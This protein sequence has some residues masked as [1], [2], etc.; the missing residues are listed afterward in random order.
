M[1]VSRL[2]HCVTQITNFYASNQDLKIVSG[3]PLL[4]LVDD[5]A[6]FD[7]GRPVP[8]KFRALPA[9]PFLVP[10]VLDGLLSSGQYA[11]VIEMVPGEADWYCAAA[12]RKSGGMVLTG[13][14]DLL[15][16]D[17]GPKGG[18]IFYD[19]L[20]LRQ[21]DMSTSFCVLMASVANS[22]ETA[23]VL[24]VDSI[25]RLAFELKED[26]STTLL[27]AVRRSN[28]G[29]GGA[30][31]KALYDNFSK[32]YAEEET[33]SQHLAGN[34]LCPLVDP[35]LSELV[36]QFSMS[37]EETLHM[38]LP[39]II[40]DPSRASAWNVSQYL[41]SHAYSIIAASKNKLK[42]PKIFE[43]SRRD[44]R[45]VPDSVHIS[46]PSEI[47]RSTRKLAYRR[48]AIKSQFPAVPNCLVWRISA[49][50][51]VY[52][53]YIENGR[54]LPSRKA[55]TKAFCGNEETFI[56]WQDVHLSAQIQAALY[57]F[58][59]LTQ[60][61]KVYSARKGKTKL[62]N[63]VDESDLRRTNLPA[64]QQLV[65]SRQESAHF[66]TLDLR[67]DTLFEFMIGFSHQEQSPLDAAEDSTASLRAS[68]TAAGI[69]E[70]QTKWI[71]VKSKK[72]KRQNKAVSPV[73]NTAPELVKNIYGVLADT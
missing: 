25:Q 59:L 2:E 23:K 35:R 72:V 36:V 42:K 29:F 56:S 57:S 12:A 69:S 44:V 16:Y 65:P 54:S 11:E 47:N 34:A 5:H 4:P 70:S 10:A 32:E 7:F 1:R 22:T 31:R 43:Y 41:R 21:C 28:N 3:P 9:A 27:E 62:E 18:V 64:I 15:V 40:E 33:I 39:F 14:S 73:V 37:A 61:L 24:G 67:L 63:A 49:I 8:A 53:W 68:S 60:A 46:E 19:Q 20:E 50:I 13:D 38:Y 71:T 51:E 6:L 52:S 45:I 66:A 30:N 17:L 55:L 48:D 26:R 58:R